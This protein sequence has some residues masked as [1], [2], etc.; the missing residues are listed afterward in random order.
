MNNMDEDTSMNNYNKPANLPE[1][2]DPFKALAD[3]RELHDEYPIS[4]CVGCH[5]KRR[6]H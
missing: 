3:A 2:V 4:Y 1:I 6:R 5:Q